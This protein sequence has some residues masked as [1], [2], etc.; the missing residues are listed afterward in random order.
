MPFL[1]DETSSLMQFHFTDTWP[2]IFLLTH[3]TEGRIHDV[4]ILDLLI[5]EPDS[6]Y[7]MDRGYLDFKR[8]YTIHQSGAFFVTRAKRNFNIQR[9][10]SRPVDKSKYLSFQQVR[11]RNFLY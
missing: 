7:V 8:L 11:M 6:F 5:V 2:F 3:I 9:R 10:Y 1:L 4:K